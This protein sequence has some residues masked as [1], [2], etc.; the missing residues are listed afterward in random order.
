MSVKYLL[1]TPQSMLRLTTEKSNVTTFTDGVTT[2]KCGLPKDCEV[3]TSD[4]FMF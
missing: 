4:W 2:K 3:D 1:L